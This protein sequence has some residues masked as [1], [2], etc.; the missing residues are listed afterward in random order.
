MSTTP[1]RAVLLDVDGTL[2]DSNDAHA[3]AWIDTLAESGRPVEFETVRRLI[4]KGGD[5][6]LP[7][8]T[9]I[10]IDSAEGKRLAKRRAAIFTDRYLPTLQPFPGTR[11]LLERMK[12]DGLALVIATSAKDAELEGLLDR[13]GIAD[14]IEKEATSDD[15]DASKPDPDIV[16]AALGKVKRDADE[17]VMLGDTPYDVAA[18]TAAGVRVI[19]FRCG[20][21]HEAELH[22]ALAVYDGPADL[23]ARYDDAP[24]LGSAA[25]RRA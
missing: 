18:A 6:L 4:G 13:A 20:G 21:W 11:A 12:A 25:T 7:E 16:E 8:V 9:G 15:A 1:L 2:L 17:C 5:K 10:E 22:G 24:A 23:L 14:L 3:R 19:A